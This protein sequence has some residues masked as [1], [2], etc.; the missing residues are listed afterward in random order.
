MATF[1]LIPGAGSTPW[2][3]HLVEPRL[4]G[5]GHDVVAVELPAD[6]DDARFDDYARV[7]IEQLGD[8]PDPVLV[9]QSMGAYTAGLVADRIPVRLV[10]LVAAMVPTGGESGGDWWEASG[11]S[12]AR[13]ELIAAQGWDPAEADDPVHMFVHDVPE[14]L[15]AAAF[16]HTTDQSG[17]PFEDPWPLEAWPNVPTRFL[18]CRDDRLFP[19]EFLRELVRER[20]GIEADELPGGHLPALAHPDE[21][22][23]RLLAYERSLTP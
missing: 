16:E 21:L 7:A 17:T 3:W 2:Y 18:L 14:E 8:R 20:L 4:R 15:A 22:A 9:A 19:A 13:A 10:V 5:A 11:Q 6:D 12:A 1:L 23:D